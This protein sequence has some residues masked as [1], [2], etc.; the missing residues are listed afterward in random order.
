MNRRDFLKSTVAASAAAAAASPVQSAESMNKTA[1]EFYELRFYYLRKGPQQKLFEQFHREAA[2]PALKRHGI[3]PVGIFNVAVGPDAPMM[4]VLAL[5]PSLES[6]A[7]IASRLREDGEFQRAGAPFLKATAADPAYMRM[8]SSLLMSISGMPK[9]EIPPATALNKPRIFELR[10]YQ[11]HN[12][13]ASRAKIEMFNNGELA[14]FRRTGLQP[15]FFGETLIGSRLPNL[16]YLLT[17]ESLAAREKNWATF[18]EDPEWKRMSN[19]PGYTDAEIVTN[20]SNVLLN[21][22]PFSQI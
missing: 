3:G 7:T 14:I 15:V 5:H 8:E 13:N 17:F 2:L 22:A 20:V 21:P 1:R 4:V 11:S 19:T 9:L 18:R 16:T 12:E 6:C 10:T